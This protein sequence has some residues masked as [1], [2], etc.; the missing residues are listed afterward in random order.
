MTI[1]G[2]DVGK[3]SL[4]GVRIGRA[5]RIEKSY[6]VKNDPPAITAFMDSLMERRP[7]V[8]V[9]SE[10]TAEYHKPLAM[11]CLKRGIPY[12]LLNPITTKQF[13]RATVRK[14]KT[15]ISDAWIIAKLALQGEG[16]LLTE[17]S[18]NPLKAVIR[19]TSKLARIAQMIDLMHS[20]ISQVLPEETTLKE[21]LLHQRD[22]L[23]LSVKKLHKHAAEKSDA[24]LTK[25]LATI[26]GIGPTIATTLIAEIGE[27]GRFPSGKA[28]AAYAGLDP[29]VRQSG[30][31]LKRNTRIT[32]RGSPY[33]RRAIYLAASIA[34]LHD[35]ELKDY[36]GKK[37][38]EGKR[39]KEAVV[40]TA[41][42]MLYRVYAVWKRGTAY[43]PDIHKKT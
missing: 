31:T 1:I 29:K 6:V 10:S 17:S 20:R 24:R 28:L 19:T 40:A 39:Y 32:K 21:E 18:F 11:E 9:A 7:R 25:L 8:T 4:V 27:I 12:R 43:V 38:G 3:E 15:D 26:P 36:F 13:T 37:A 35:A 33:L 30:N 2:F 5:A 42:K 41:R 34:V 16:T 23:R 14:R 22:S